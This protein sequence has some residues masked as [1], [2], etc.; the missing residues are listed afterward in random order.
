MKINNY[1]NFLILEKFDDNIIKELKRLGVKDKKEINAYLYNAHRG[2][3]AEYLRLKGKK[4]TFGMLKALFDDALDA[5]RKTELRVGGIKMVHR[6]V[7][8]LMAPFFPILAVVGYILG[9]SRAFNKIIAP[10]LSDPGNDYPAFLKKIIDATMKVAEGDLT[11]PKDRF[12]RAFVVSDRLVDAI[13]P[14]VLQKFS[15]ELSEKMSK[16]DQE[17]EVP[18]NFIE[19]ELKSY[20]NNRFDVNPLI[21]MK[22]AM[23]QAK[24]A[25]MVDSYKKDVQDIMDIYY[26]FF[27]EFEYEKSNSPSYY[28]TITRHDSYGDS[29]EI[30]RNY[31][32]D[33]NCIMIRMHLHHKKVNKSKGFD[34]LKNARMKEILEEAHKRVIA[35]LQPVDTLVGSM[36]DDLDIIYFFDKPKFERY[37]GCDIYGSNCEVNIPP[38]GNFS[39]NSRHFNIIHID[40]KLKG[41][42]MACLIAYHDNA[43]YYLPNC[44]FDHIIYK[45]EGT[46]FERWIEDEWV[47]ACRKFKIRKSTK[48]LGT[49]VIWENKQLLPA[50]FM[51]WLKDNVENFK[52][53]N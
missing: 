26:D 29:F 35:H 42:N 43:H 20:L 44:I 15:I 45:Y 16:L 34:G 7:P 51:V 23:S 50:E 27:D 47:K 9:T 28:E 49:K 25:K 19:N 3:L 53:Y 52:N 14:E 21:P 24:Y 30:G 6:L 36:D 1:Q 18:D 22:E 38:I 39:I 12:T 31:Q 8:I 10:I 2:R 37:N 4:F 40:S 17:S 46:P 48:G 5:K 41:S 32:Y 13:K 33:A 11:A